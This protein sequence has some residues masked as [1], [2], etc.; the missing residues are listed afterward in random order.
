MHALSFDIRHADGRHERTTAQAARV[1]IGSGGHCDV[2]LSADQAAFEHVVIESA[3]PG[4][5]WQIRCLAAV[6]PSTLDGAPFT[7]GPLRATTD[8]RIGATQIQTAQVEAT[9]KAKGRTVDA[10]MAAK[11]LVIAALG[12]AIVM[13]SRTAVEERVEAPR[14]TPDLFAKAVTACPRTDP[15]EARAI[16]DDQRASA[17]GARERSPFDPREARSAIKSYETAAAC[18]R[19]A[20]NVEASE[21]AAQNAKRTRDET[22]L[23]FRARRVRLERLLLVKDYELASQDVAVLLALTESQPTDYGRWLST[24]AQEIKANQVEKKQ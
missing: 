12:V 2:R 20:Q 9:E 13:M 14:R 7:A 8:L 22:L 15:A 24:V 23:D 19:L 17:D 11:L 10:A 6:P 16:A 3:G 1:L 4:A 18:Y 21:E 5:G